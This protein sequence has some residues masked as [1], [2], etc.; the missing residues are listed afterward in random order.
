[1]R[2]KPLLQ[3]L[4]LLVLPR[5]LG[6]KGCSSPPCECHQEDDFRVTCKDIYRIPSLPSSTQ[7]L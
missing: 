2:S 3:L 4:L 7:T 6:A 1:M 5:S